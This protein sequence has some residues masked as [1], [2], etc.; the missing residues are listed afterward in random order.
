MIYCI[1]DDRSIR[2]LITYTL[3]ISGFDAEG[4]ENAKDFFD[5][6][7]KAVPELILLDIMLEGKDGLQILKEL[8]ENDRFKDIPVIMA[9]AKT[10]E[11]D[12]VIGL[13]SGA[14]DY[15]A[16]P[17]GMM[18]MVSR[19]KAVLRRS[20]KASVDQIIRYG[21]IEIDKAKYSVR[22]GN[23][24]IDLTPKEFELLLCLVENPGIVFSREQLLDKIWGLNYLGESRTIDVHINTL[25]NK[26]GF[27]GKYIIT[28]HGIGY[29][30]KEEDNG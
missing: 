2:E 16:K 27:L 22:I 17:F 20:K 4:F 18:E 26:L 9:T 25:R 8:K 6:L 29:C 11:F 28:M 23:D 30:L 10:S 3:K 21:E 12:K 24:P 19:I 13:D 1:E 5:A 15:L 7:E 14:D